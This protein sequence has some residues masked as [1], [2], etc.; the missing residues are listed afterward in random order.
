MEER[1]NQTEMPRAV[2]GRATNRSES[3]VW[4]IA[5]AM[6]LVF[7]LGQILTVLAAA[8]AA[9]AFHAEAGS[10]PLS[11]E[12]VAVLGLPGLV[13]VLALLDAL[14]LWVF[15]RLAQRHWIG[16]AFLPPLLYLGFGV[17]M[18]WLLLAQAVTWVFT[19]A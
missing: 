7:A 11:V 17:V 4:G 12:A 13:V 14:V 8:P 9:I 19:N 6:A 2:L 1:G 18:L 5:I 16:F 10:T 3:I 15:L